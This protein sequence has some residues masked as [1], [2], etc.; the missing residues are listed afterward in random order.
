MAVIEINNSRACAL[1]IRTRGE[2]SGMAVYLTFHRA[3]YGSLLLEV[4][5]MP[6]ARHSRGIRTLHG[7]P[8]T[9]L[10]IIQACPSRPLGHSS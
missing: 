3:H 9:V 1:T 4:L 5:N 10:E 7:Q 6:F 8:S 2:F